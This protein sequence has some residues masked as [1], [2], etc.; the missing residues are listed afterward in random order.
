MCCLVGVWC[1]L[2][3]FSGLVHWASQFVSLFWLVAVFVG[4]RGNIVVVA[5]RW[6]TSSLGAWPG[7]RVAL[8]GYTG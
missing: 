3:R 4:G 1:P 7:H 8:Q 5:V 2:A 6:V